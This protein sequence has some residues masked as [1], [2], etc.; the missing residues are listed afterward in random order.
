M[1]GGS[2]VTFSISA[3]D[4][5]GQSQVESAIAAAGLPVS[6]WVPCFS[7]FR[8]A[9]R[10]QQV[11]VTPAEHPFAKDSELKEASLEEL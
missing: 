3:D 5:M 8:D 2:D 10:I 4:R 7:S 9:K 6:A 11:V 1:S